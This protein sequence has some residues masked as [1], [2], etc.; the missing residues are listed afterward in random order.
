MVDKCFIGVDVSK[1]WV[2]IAVHGVT[3]VQRIDNTAEAIGGW[4]RAVD[5]ESVGL[6]AFEPTGGYERTLRR[7]LVEAG[8]PFARVHPNEIA[9]FRGRRGGKAKTD[10]LDAILLA[11]FAAVEL[12]GRGL[13][14]V[15]GDAVLAEMVARRRQLVA[16]LQAERCRAAT[17]HGA[18]VKDSLATLTATLAAALAALDAAIASHV[19]ATPALADAAACLRTLKGTGPV[20]AATLLGE[21]PE[22]G[23]LSGKEIA[24]LVGLAPCTRESGK[25]RGRARTGHGRAGVRQVLFNAAR[26]A[27]R[28]NP[29]MRNFY[30]RLVGERRRP[31]KVAL[32]AVMR[33]ML[34]TLN[35]MARERK[36]WKHACQPA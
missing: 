16:M 30:E 25:Q 20:T 5:A 3:A 7:C 6:I 34:V 2:D 21:L 15:D 4:A 22:L 33:K 36:P 32:V 8:L 14:A 18:W 24:A 1:G 12:S 17:A 10:R 29:V 13:T 35:A 11:A 19:A 23:R 28:W 27:I 9:A 31:G 26:S